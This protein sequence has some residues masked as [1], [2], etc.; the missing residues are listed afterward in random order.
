MIE[1]TLPAGSFECALQAFKWGADAVYLGLT[2]FSARKGAKNFTIDEL[3]VIKEIASKTGK[4]VYVT[5]NTILNDEEMALLIPIIRTLDLLRIDALIIQDPGLASVVRSITPSLEIHASTQLAVHSVEGVKQLAELGFTRVV[6][7]RE[8]TLSEIEHI[9]RECPDISI[10]VF[11]HGAMCYGFSGLCMASNILTSRS[12]NKGECSQICRSYF[13]NDDHRS[14]YPFSMKDLSSSKETIRTL[15]EIGIDSL[16]IEGRMKSPEYVAAAARYYRLLL[17]EKPDDIISEAKQHLDTA[18][19][20]DQSG[21]WLASYD[22]ESVASARTTPSLITP[23]YPGHTG[24]SVGTLYPYRREHNGLYEVRF[25]EAAH[26]RDGLMVLLEK[27]GSI[28]EAVKFSLSEMYDLSMKK[29]TRTE[30]G[31]KVLIRLPQHISAEN[32]VQLYRIKEHDA[33]LSKE[34]KE[35]GRE[36]RHPAALSVV[37]CDD[38]VTVE[39]SGLPEWTCSNVKQTLPLDIQDAK[40]IQMVKEN[41]EKVFSQSDSRYINVESVSVTYGGT[42]ELEWLFIPV[43]A[44]KNVRRTV[45]NNL[46]RRIEE[47]INRPLGKMPAVQQKG[48]RLPER[49]SV[50]PIVCESVFFA[51]LAGIADRLMRGEKAENLLK[52]IDRY[53]FV[54]LPP[55]CFNEQEAIGYLS[56]IR[57]LTDTPLLI[58]V[59]NIAHFSYF[60]DLSYIIDIYCYIANRESAALLSSMKPD[61][62]GAY[63]WIERKIGDTAD[64][65]V[66]IS[67]AGE[68][69]TPLL[70]ISRSCYRYDVLGL[71]CKGCTRN[72]HWEVTQNSRRYS[73]DVHNCITTVSEK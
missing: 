28:S 57:S 5:I 33:T 38:S 67:D 58:G 19:S 27:K 21:G 10:K 48:I 11:I 29:L 9:R 71:G 62:L 22:K 60:S 7:S 30:S 56:Q 45:F 47:A 39:I 23:A 25:T 4:K 15:K 54:P 61:C 41:I 2:S 1:L 36:F 14:I 6:L 66:V 70:F 65:P 8:L 43:S 72:G 18:F 59:N 34:A 16:K 35:S 73:V 53:L 40:K 46:D 13:S 26:L 37:L 24:V 51:D 55:V 68:D 3:S 50:S 31:K 12:A 52:R 42:R 17:D 63:H 44:L 64:Y 49:D 32:P 69:F 20:R